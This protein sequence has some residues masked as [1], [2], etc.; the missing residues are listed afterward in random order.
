MRHVITALI[1]SASLSGFSALGALSPPGP[2]V[3]RQALIGAWRL[4]SID[5]LGPNGVLVDPVFGANSQGLIIYD[6]S[7]WMSVQIFSADRPAMP[8]PA[9]RTTDPTDAQANSVK[10]AA[11][12][13][14][15]AYFGTWDYDAGTSTITHHLRSSLLPYETGV[16]YRRSISINGGRL[17]LTVSSQVNGEARQRTLT[18]ERLAA[19]RK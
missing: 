2:H 17:E 18:W 5:Y 4:V 6:P 9:T 8:R 1:I 13:S 10:A 19:T 11:F 16:D 14:Y 15:Y 12:D 7:G 3:N